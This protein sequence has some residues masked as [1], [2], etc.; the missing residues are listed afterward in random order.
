MSTT[1]Q[2]GVT[3]DFLNPQGEIGFGD[4][5]LSLLEAPG[6]AWEFLAENERE[7]TTEQVRKY[8][9]LLVLGPKVTAATLEGADRLTVVARFGVGFD[10]V[11]TAACTAAGVAVTITP[12]GVRR[13]VAVA[14]LTLLLA[15]AHKLVLKD[16]LT[17]SGRWSEKLNHMGCGVTGRTLGVI[18]L[19]NIGREI[20]RLVE[21]LQM[22]RLAYDPYP[23]APLADVA[24][25][26]L[27][28]LLRQSDFVIV[29]CAL[30]PQTHRLL[31]AS[32]LALMQPSAFLIN[33]ARGPIVD[34]AA[35]TEALANG[36]LAGAGLDVFEQE[37]IDPADPLLKLDNVILS[38]HAICWT[39][40]CFRG[41]GQSACRGLLE[42]AAG[43]PPD[44]VVNR[45]VLSSERFLARLARFRR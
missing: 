9:A 16:W 3:R 11:D 37:P 13:P 40:E 36:R 43:R 20:M 39:D 44:H 32:R 22:R 26:S 29:A 2:I 38:P 19:G 24:L 21:P 27:E 34:Q 4:I 30:T 18:G 25:T 41:I 45:E 17:R 42:A 1:F 28:D 31:D 8:D 15:C 35:L 12:D 33:V 7:L 14:A 6:V 10:N 23:G 5:G